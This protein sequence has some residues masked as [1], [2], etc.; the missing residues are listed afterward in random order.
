VDQNWLKYKL[1]DTI[2]FLEGLMW[3]LRQRERKERGKEKKNQL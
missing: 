1:D 2:G 3:K